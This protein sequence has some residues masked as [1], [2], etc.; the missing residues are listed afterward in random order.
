VFYDRDGQPIDVLTWGAMFEDGPGRTVA[1]DQVGRYRITTMW[2]GTDD[3]PEPGRLPLIYGS[4]LFR[5]KALEEE[6][7]TATEVAARAAHDQLLAEVRR[8]VALG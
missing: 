2:L 6:I 1:N 8:R 3:D 5:G 7:R 4:A